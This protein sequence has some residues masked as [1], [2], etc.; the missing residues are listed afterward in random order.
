M[1]R[2]A[3]RGYAAAR[4]QYAGDTPGAGFAQ[5]G[6]IVDGSYG[7]E[8][9]CRLSGGG[10]WI[11]RPVEVPGSR[12]LTFEAGANVAL[13]LRTWP[14]EQ[15][16]KCLLALHP[17]DAA[18]LTRQQ[19]GTLLSL[20]QACHA[21]GHELLLELIPPRELPSDART[22]ARGMAAVY[23]AGVKPDWW[24]LVPPLEAAA[25]HGIAQVIGDH[26]AH[27]RGV[28]LLGLEASEDVLARGFQ[29]AAG[30]P[31]CKGFAV[32]RSIFGDAANAW[33]AGTLDDAGVVTEVAARYQRLIA[34]WQQSRLAPAGIEPA[35]LLKATHA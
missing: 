33:L 11:G 23:A 29:V 31:L 18:E 27:C 32:G 20:Q 26:D 24:K 12:P 4:E 30:Q 3:E 13:A 35:H 22:L 14:T 9:L 6:V 15:V 28:L 34:L 19:L 25:W 10:W 8:V 2:A 17:D 16:V 7:E 5:P 1:A 21:T